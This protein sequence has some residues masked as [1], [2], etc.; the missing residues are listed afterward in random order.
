[1]FFLVT[2]LNLWAA[3]VSSFPPWGADAVPDLYTPELAGS[4][5]FSTSQGGGPVSALNPAQGGGA[6]RIIFDIGYLGLAGLGAESGYGNA[7][8]A[9]ML[10]P[11]RYGVFGGS[12]RF[13]QSP[14]DSFPVQT[15]FGGNISAAKEL[16]PGMS[17]GAGINFGFGSDWTV[18]LD[19]GFHYNTGKLGPLHNFTWALAL[20]GIGKSWTPS[21]FTPIGGVSFDLL[22]VEGAGDKPDPFV[23]NAA[24]DLSLPSV[25]Y[26][27]R[28]SMIFKTGLKAVIA[29]TFTVSLSWPGGSGLNVRELTEGGE[30]PA[31]PSV[32]LGI[33]IALPSGGKRIAGGRL[34]TDGN[35]AVNAAFKPLYKGVTAMGGG[36]TWAVGVVDKKPPVIVVDY[37]ETVYFSPNNDGKADFLEFPISITDARYVS[38]WVMEVKDEDGAVVRTYR[39]KELRHETQ[40]VRNFFS[41]LFAVKTQVEV[42]PNLGWDGIGDSGEL[43]PDGRYFF[44]ITAADDNGNAAVSD[45]YEVVLDNTPPEISIE[46]MAEAQRVFSPDG[47]GNKDAIAFTPYGSSE[48]VWESGIF[49]TSGAQIRGF[50]NESGQPGKRDW[51]GKDDAGIIVSD[52]VYTYR[53]WATDRAQNT[54][55]A[56]MEN[57]VVSTI[58]P[59]VQVFIGDS[60]FSPNGDGIKDTV[61]MNLS[62]PVQEGITGWAIQIKDKQGRTQRTIQNGAAAAVPE[63]FAYDGK[64]E[65]GR[66][67]NEGEY[68]AEFSVSYRNGYVSQA[69][70]PPFNLDIT[71]PRATVRAEYNAFSPNNDGHQDEMILRQEGSPELV[72]TGDIRRANGRPGE[73]PVRSFRFTGT[74]PARLTWDGHGDAGTF[75][76]DG[77]YTYELYAVDQAGNSGRSEKLHFRLSTADTPVMIT[78]DQRAFSPNGDGVKD[79]VNLVPQ[80]QIAEGI[81]SYKVDV[82]DS[83]NSVVR[84]FEGRTAPPASITWNGRTGANTAAP[85]GNYKARL[86]LRYEQG[87]QPA[88]VSLPFTLDTT[89]PKVELSAPYTL[90]SPNGSRGDIPLNVTTEWE[91]EWEAAIVDARGGVV[92]TWNWT[93]GAPPVAWDGTDAAGNRAPDGTYQF[94]VRSTDAA[95][96]STKDGISNI[97]LD[98]RIPRVILTTSATAI[99]P[100]PNQSTDMVRFGIICTL[101]DGIESWSLELKDEQGTTLRRFAPVQTARGVA[102][103]PDFI[104]WNGL[105]ENGE[106]R[107]GRFTPSLTVRY[108]KGDTVFAETSSV[109]VDVSGPELSISHRPQYF[110]PDNDGIDDDLFISLGAKDASP[111][112]SWSVEIREPEPPYLL[113]YRIGGRGRPAETVKWDGRS[114]KGE[115]VQSATD[116]PVT[117]TATD[118]LG[119]SSTIESRIGI[120][121]LVI[122]EGDRL[123][124]QIPSIVFRENAADFEGIPPDRAGNNVRVLRRLAEILNKFRDYKIQV[125]GHANP[126]ARTTRE[127]RNELQP[128]SEARA[129]TTVNMLVEFGVARSRLSSTGMG[130]TRP[131]VKYEDRDN[132]WKNRRVEFILIK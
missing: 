79:T 107:E 124:I 89:P 116:Y 50:E 21:W 55:T 98:A 22:R 70:S 44:A 123:R 42:P 14:F 27:P 93:G 121:V 102:P 37:P 59:K 54:A 28:T 86:E 104:G 25:I 16:Y 82:L 92:R 87:N 77:E 26:F 30:F 97:V 128:L 23:L 68:Q 1:M 56:A 15:T 103:P 51:D 130:G 11:T 84:T 47:D 9:G 61:I 131:V 126:V 88:A 40:G 83:A 41:R 76:A 111:I 101:P 39:N 4:G 53:I 75:A 66:V 80:I 65:S 78:T 3:D 12:M 122:R 20:R 6:Q 95:G 71:P 60:W 57:I 8:E 19:T 91:D 63:Q 110:S 113:F 132:W 48:E 2:G 43:S 10:F 109:L 99:A 129:K 96:N 24:A 73:K 120:D 5:G 119:N 38:S 18:S 106:L 17:V 72:W 49:N 115:L 114:N 85:D 112:E 46:A 62:V 13:I 108:V 64:N 33:N 69:L 81:I 67:L 118:A 58:Q 74:P 105:A 117:Y 32:G 31:I 52:G 127:E 34:P 125:E 7:I 100:K 35:I 45:T 94:T 29:E 90:F 36:L